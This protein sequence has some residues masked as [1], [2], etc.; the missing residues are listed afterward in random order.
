MMN[1]AKIK[2]EAEYVFE[3][4]NN[5]TALSMISVSY[6]LMTSLFVG[7]VFFT[8]HEYSYLIRS[9]TSTSSLWALFMFV[10][11]I[12][13]MLMGLYQNKQFNKVSV[14]KVISVSLIPFLTVLTLS[15]FKDGNYFDD[16]LVAIDISLL[17][18]L[19]CSAM[20]LKSKQ[21]KVE[22]AFINGWFI[23]LSDLI[24]SCNHNED[25]ISK[26]FGLEIFVEL[27]LLKAEIDSIQ[28]PNDFIFKS[29]GLINQV[30][31]SCKEKQTVI[32]VKL[33]TTEPKRITLNIDG[34]RITLSLE[35]A[36]KL[37]SEL[38]RVLIEADECEIDTV[39]SFD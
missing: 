24:K 3:Q 17:S 31:K 8:D 20:W 27:K 32:A 12:I 16:A 13:P 39:L 38:D 7:I 29:K 35:N 1:Y 6:F 14:T 33:R 11:F 21:F 22:K 23:H 36:Q 26:E 25:E 18:V 9:L 19:V 15:K 4:W 37:S 2:E 30:R 34:K 5:P 28:N 10:V